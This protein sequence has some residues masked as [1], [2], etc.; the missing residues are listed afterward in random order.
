MLKPDQRIDPVSHTIDAE[1]CLEL[2]DIHDFTDDELRHA[3]AGLS[4][5]VNDRRE[6]SANYPTI[7]RNYSTPA[8]AYGRLVTVGKN[9]DV[10]FFARLI[11]VTKDG[12]L[13]ET[14]GMATTYNA[15]PGISDYERG[16]VSDERL[17]ALYRKMQTNVTFWCGER[18]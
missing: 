12:D 18:S 4:Q 3:G 13:S 10:G 2:V 17:K 11:V 16:K 7:A 1:R 8:E 5:V 14:L 15:T 9:K 6:L